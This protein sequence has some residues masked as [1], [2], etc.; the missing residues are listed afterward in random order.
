MAVFFLLLRAKPVYL[1]KRAKGVTMSDAK[2]SIEA[3]LS[4]SERRL[5]L[6]GFISLS[7]L[8][9]GGW[10]AFGQSVYLDQLF[11]GLAGCF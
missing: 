11:A 4:P 8:G 3:D 6:L 2:Q 5:V 7:L 10:A 1:A 9:L